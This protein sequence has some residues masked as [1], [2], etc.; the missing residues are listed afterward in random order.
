MPWYRLVFAGVCEPEEPGGRAGGQAAGVRVQ[1]GRRA[2][3]P[4]PGGVHA[5]TIS[6]EATKTNG[7]CMYA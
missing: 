1:G 6:P 7:I 3:R 4:R 2:R 5:L